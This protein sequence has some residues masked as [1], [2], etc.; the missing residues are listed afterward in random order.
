MKKIR[1]I[2]SILGITLGVSGG[3]FAAKT[4]SQNKPAQ[5]SVANVAFQ[6]KDYQTAAKDPSTTTYEIG[7]QGDYTPSNASWSLTNIGTNQYRLQY[8][9]NS[10]YSNFFFVTALVKI[11]LSMPSY[12]HSNVTLV[13][14]PLRTECSTT[15]SP[16]HAAEITVWPQ[17]YVNY[18]T[19]Y[20]DYQPQFTYNPN[21]SLD[22]QPST[23]SL[24]RVAYQGSTASS[25]PAR[26]AQ[27]SVRAE[28][29][30]QILDQNDNNN[31]RNIYFALSGYVEST[32]ASGGHI[33]SCS[34]DF[35]ITETNTGYVT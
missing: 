17:S 18:S 7:K 15:G 12:S 26:A 2:F 35:T 5:A 24:L 27:T 34:V 25:H 10:S 28:C 14:N 3:F 29:K 16:D 4:E 33:Y 23:N 11:Q 9:E 8:T 21:N 30:N 6:S 13:F 32:S 22:N 31:Y 19:T 20:L 1:L